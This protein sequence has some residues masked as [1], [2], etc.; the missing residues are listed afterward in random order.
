MFPL[1]PPTHGTLMAGIVVVLTELFARDGLPPYSALMC[2]GE[3]GR[4]G[5]PGGAGLG[6]T[7]G[8]AGRGEGLLVS[9]GMR[10]DGSDS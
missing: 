10:D 7:R 9:I 8:G 3:G 2:A 5:G 6:L 4:E 1:P